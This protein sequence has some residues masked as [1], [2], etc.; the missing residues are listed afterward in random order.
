VS[1]A[2]GG[3]PDL[4]EVR[5]QWVG[6]PFER[7]EHPVEGDDLA[8]WARA[9]G[10]SDQR[11]VDPGHPDFQAHP[12]YTARFSARPFLPADFPQFGDG[13]ID[14]GKRVDV[15]APVRPGDI[16]SSTTT[17]AEIYE[18]TGRSGTM[19]FVVHRMEFTNQRGEPVATVD[20]RMI[21]SLGTS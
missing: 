8:V 10:E 9:C 14:G 6:V 18:K 15:T 7:G 3:G 13:G 20:S 5:R 4:E 2:G 19:V 11:F 12:T 17:I 1:A 21:R 16:L